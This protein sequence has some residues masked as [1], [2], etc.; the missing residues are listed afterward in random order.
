[1]TS[2][3]WGLLVLCG[4]EST[5]NWRR[6]GLKFKKNSLNFNFEYIAEA[7]SLGIAFGTWEP[8]QL[9]THIINIS[10]VHRIF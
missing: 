5:Y 9:L 7:I 3:D 4:H 8:D 2:A 1:M 10:F 6:L